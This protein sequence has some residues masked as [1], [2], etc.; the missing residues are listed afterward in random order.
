[1]TI[2]FATHN[3]HKVKELNDILKETPFKVLS[4]RDVDYHKE[5]IEDGATFVENAAIKAHQVYQDLG[6]PTLADDSG[7][8]VDA[9]AGAPGIHSAR[10]GGV[11]ASSEAK[12]ELLLMELD[13]IP[14]EERGA[15]YTCCFYF[16]KDE[17]ESFFVE[18]EC[19]GVIGFHP[20][21][22][23]GFGY[24]PLFYLPEYNKT[25]AELSMEDKN[26]I[27][28]RGKATRE[29]I[30]KLYILYEGIL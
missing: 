1:M 14:F 9:L 8:C 17:M 6:F 15:H 25:M 21:G 11:G 28:H 27:S 24:D 2:I 7:L 26:R 3:E 12:N 29:L 22:K 16:I 20:V 13:G 5:I 4:L 23:G 10:F 19:H 18:K 30:E